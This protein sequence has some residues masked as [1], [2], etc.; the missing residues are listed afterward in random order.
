MDGFAEEAE[1]K[2]VPDDDEAFSSS[3]EDV[4]VEVIPRLAPPPEEGG[5][6]EIETL[7]PLNESSS[8][9]DRK[10]ESPRKMPRGKSVRKTKKA[11]RGKKSAKKTKRVS[12]SKVPKIKKAIQKLLNSLPN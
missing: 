4:P 10:E 3:S 9:V 6:E 2:I 1:I 8:S 5:S 11:S 7:Q 12:L